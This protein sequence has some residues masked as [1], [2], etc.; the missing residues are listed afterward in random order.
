ML[1][2]RV[3]LGFASR[4]RENKNERKHERNDEPVFD[5]EA[6]NSF[7]AELNRAMQQTDRGRKDSQ[8]PKVPRLSRISSYMGIGGNGKQ[9]S[10][11]RHLVSLDRDDTSTNAHNNHSI[12]VSR[13]D[14]ITSEGVFLDCDETWHK[15]NITQIMEMVACTIMS[16]K[17]L[18]FAMQTAATYQKNSEAS[19]CQVLTAC[20]TDGI[21]EP[22]PRHFNGSICSMIE[23]FR[24][25]LGQVQKLRAS[26]QELQQTRAQETCEFATVAEE[27]TMRE[28]GFKSEI[29]RLEQIIASTEEGVAPVILARSG[30]VINR[31]DG[32]IFQAKLNRLSKT[33]GES[34]IWYEKRWFVPLTTTA[35]QTMSL[36]TTRPCNILKER[37]LATCATSRLPMSPRRLTSVG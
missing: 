19:P 7:K 14:S 6:L 13:L 20:L 23:E 3:W 4:T 22:I 8:H 9:H 32:K 29:K 37:R 26:F 10:P 35:S 5:A 12:R 33:E 1:G 15:P 28:A 34:I 25:A 16:S 2:D 30:S 24:V 21:S 11:P 31:N 18:L 17:Q 27:W 36:I